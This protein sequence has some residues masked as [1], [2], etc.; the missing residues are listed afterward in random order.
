MV[1]A[2]KEEKKWYGTASDNFRFAAAVAQFGLLLRNSEFKED[3]SW[4]NILS[5]AKAAMGKDAEGYRAEFVKLVE[6]A[7]GLAKAAPVEEEL[8]DEGGGE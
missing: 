6:G 3:A 7:K 4:K 2:V 5:L 1:H 8:E